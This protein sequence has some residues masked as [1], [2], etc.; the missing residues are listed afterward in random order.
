MTL[1]LKRS[2]LRMWLLALGGIPLLVMSIDVLTNRTITN[3]LR[4]MIFEPEATQLYEPRDVIYAWGMLIFGGLLVLWGLKELFYPTKVVE[5]RPDGIAIR[6]RGPL[7]GPDVIPWELIRDIR[8]GEIRDEEEKLPLLE[9]ELF[10]RGDLPPHPWGARWLDSNLLGILTQDWTGSPEDITKRI[11][12]FA[13]EVARD[14]R[15]LRTK[16][17]WETET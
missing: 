17:L 5:G 6:L 2:A 1:I 11:T 9:I 8:P 13:V 7:R 15:R 4:E 14:E 12:E 3:R 10:S 16:R